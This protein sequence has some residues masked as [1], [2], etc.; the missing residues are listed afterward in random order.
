MG[1]H[2]EVVVVAFA[3]CY[4]FGTHCSHLD[5]CVYVCVLLLCCVAR[6]V[7]CTV[8]GT[9]VRPNRKSAR[10]WEHVNGHT[11]NGVAPRAVAIGAEATAAGIVA[12]SDGDEGPV[13]WGVPV[14]RVVLDA[15]ASRGCPMP[16]VGADRPV[17]AYGSSDVGRA[18]LQLVAPRLKSHDARVRAVEDVTARADVA[19]GVTAACFTVFNASTTLNDVAFSRDAATVRRWL[20]RACQSTRCCGAW[21]LWAV[22]V[23]VCACSNVFFFRGRCACVSRVLL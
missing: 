15:L 6:R 13:Q 1:R 17:P 11:P 16:P 21:S 12:L 7:G 20:C 9:R 23:R 10:S 18:M 5:R 3:A 19:V 2:H 8:V 4:T 22:N 14:A